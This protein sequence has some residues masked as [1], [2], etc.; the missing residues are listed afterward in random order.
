V[1]KQLI[2]GAAFA[3]I[4]ALVAPIRAALDL[5]LISYDSRLAHLPLRAVMG[6]IREL[7]FRCGLSA[8][9]FAILRIVAL[10]DT[11]QVIGFLSALAEVSVGRHWLPR[12]W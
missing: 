7:E 1:E 12:R 6:S 11:N 4:R 3:S 2:A 10:G 8:A 5:P 9:R